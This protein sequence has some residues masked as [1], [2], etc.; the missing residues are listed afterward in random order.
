MRNKLLLLQKLWRFI[1]AA[2]RLL[3]RF[4]MVEMALLSHHLGS[5]LI[6]SVFAFDSG[7]EGD[8]STF[9]FNEVVE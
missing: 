5:F 8:V 6:A 1:S 4:I 9:D 2:V 7:D 3:Q